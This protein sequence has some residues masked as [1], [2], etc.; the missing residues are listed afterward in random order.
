MTTHGL[1]SDTPVR[2]G[3]TMA[4]LDRIAAAGIARNFGRYVG[5]IDERHDASRFAVV[6]H[7]YTAD[8]PPQRH[9]L[10]HTAWLADSRYAN[11]SRSAHG[12][13]RADRADG[14]AFAQYWSHRAA[15]APLDERV[16][17]RVA[18]HQILPM[19][20]PSQQ[21]AVRALADL[22]DYQA[23]QDALSLKQPTLNIRL[24]RARRTFEMLWHEGETPRRRVHRDRRV[25]NRSGLDSA[26]RPR[27]T[28]AQLDEIRERRYA[29]ESVRALASQYGVGRNTIY[30]LLSGESSPA[31]DPSPCGVC[32]A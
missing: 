7:L 5:D 3:Y 1:A 19:L 8:R 18:V 21:E 12:I 6:E 14:A 10:I 11:E 30:R 28:A 26:G 2:H 23:V 13:G 15:G 16:T 9:E 29:G 4:D 24:R 32:D 22:G 25:A 31:P 17:E 27:L 20:T